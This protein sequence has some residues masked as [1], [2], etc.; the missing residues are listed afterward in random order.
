[1]HCLR[2]LPGS[3]RPMTLIP[4]LKAVDQGVTATLDDPRRSIRKEA[5]DCRATWLAI[6]EP[7]VEDL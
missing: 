2:I 6:A 3:I 1:M 7:E 5:V 4:Y